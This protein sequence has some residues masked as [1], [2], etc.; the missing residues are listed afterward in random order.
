RHA[1]VPAM[2]LV[3]EVDAGLEELAQVE[4]G[5]CHAGSSFSGFDPRRGEGRSAQPVDGTG[6]S[7]PRAREPRLWLQM[8]VP[9]AEGGGVGKGFSIS[10]HSLLSLLHPSLTV[11]RRAFSR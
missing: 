9:V 3:A 11:G 10:T 2:R 4:F 8:R 5:Q 6:M 1:R 7:P